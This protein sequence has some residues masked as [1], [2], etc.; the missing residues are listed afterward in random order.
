VGCHATR[1]PLRRATRTARDRRD[2]APRLRREAARPRSK[3]APVEKAN[4]DRVAAR[5]AATG[6]G[7]PGCSARRAPRHLAARNRR[8][9]RPKALGS[10]RGERLARGWAPEQARWSLAAHWACR[11][12]LVARRY[13]GATAAGDLRPLARALAST[14]LR[15]RSRSDRADADVR[16]KPALP[17]LRERQA[18]RGGHRGLLPP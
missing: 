9:R 5:R 3:Y 14:L 12:T 7:R 17:Q 10:N 15:S 11:D 2:S 1:R 13:G 8:S 6:R 16:L 4:V 18:P